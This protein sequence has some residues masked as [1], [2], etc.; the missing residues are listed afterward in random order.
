MGLLLVMV[1]HVQQHE[2]IRTAIIQTLAECEDGLTIEE[3]S[4]SI[5][6][7]RQSVIAVLRSLQA[8]GKVFRTGFGIR[9]NP[10]K[11]RLNFGL[12]PKPA[13]PKPVVPSPSPSEPTYEEFEL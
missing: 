2:R 12:A 10:Y 11:Y 9:H 13:Q 3:L 1:K 8:E 6:G 4:V 7:R 5:F